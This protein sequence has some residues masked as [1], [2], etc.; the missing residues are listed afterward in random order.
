MQASDMSD[1]AKVDIYLKNFLVRGEIIVV[2]SGQITRVS[3]ILNDSRPFIPLTNAEIFN[4][5]GEKVGEE[6]IIIFRKDSVDFII[7]FAEPKRDQKVFHNMKHKTQQTY[8][9]GKFT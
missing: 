3:D 4:L 2:N 1:R 9:F 5:Q 8:G 7:P 6:P